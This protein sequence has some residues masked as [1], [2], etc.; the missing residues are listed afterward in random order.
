MSLQST[1]QTLEN[2]RDI[3]K[4]IPKDRNN[5]FVCYKEKFEYGI[6]ISIN[7]IYG[8]ELNQMIVRYSKN[9]IFS[10]E[11]FYIS[12]STYFRL[13]EKISENKTEYYVNS[14]YYSESLNDKLIMYIKYINKC[15]LKDIHLYGSF[16]CDFIKSDKVIDFLPSN[17]FIN[18]QDL[19]C[20]SC[21]SQI[22]SQGN[23]C[24]FCDKKMCDKCIEKSDYSFDSCSGCCIKWCCSNYDTKSYKCLKIVKTGASCDI[25]GL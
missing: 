14:K 18:I 8:N 2:P 19:I 23:K 13:F 16:L 12:S 25:C 22:I 10:S 1:F 15:I 21:N 9:N 7:D 24:D 6:T 11:D 20:N 5:Y 3:F 4:Y 17:M